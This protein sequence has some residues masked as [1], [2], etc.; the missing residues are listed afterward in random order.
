MKN[1]TQKQTKEIH[2]KVT[3]QDT[4]KRF[5]APES[6]NLNE[7]KN[8]LSETFNQKFNIQDFNVKYQ[9]QDNDLVLVTNDAEFEEAIFIS[10]S[11]L[12]RFLKFTITSGKNI[13]KNKTEKI[14]EEKKEKKEKKVEKKEEKVEEKEEKVQ[15]ILPKKINRQKVV[16]LYC[17]NPESKT[18]TRLKE[19]FEESDHKLIISYDINDLKPTHKA[20]ITF[21]G[22]FTRF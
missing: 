12:E 18:P 14:V 17:R 4:I 5:K 21:G 2:F 9:D 15:K 10:I 16:F 22:N 1:T 8:I 11:K 6:I 19:I 3:F 13:Q 7:F 20:I